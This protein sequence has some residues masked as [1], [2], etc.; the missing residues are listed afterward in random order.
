MANRK[1]GFSYYNVDTDRYQD[2]RIKRLKKDFG[3]SGISVYDYIL[4]EIY[5]VRGCFIAW[6][7]ST[8]FDVAEYFGLKETLVNEIVNYCC[9]VGLFDRELLISERV[10]TS[11]SIQTRFIEMNK[12][13]KRNDFKIPEEYAILPE[14]SIKLPEES[15]ETHAVCRKVKK[16]KGKERKKEKERI[17]DYSETSLADCFDCLSKDDIW[18]EPVIMNT[19]SSGYSN[20]SP[21]NFHSYLKSFFAKLQ[22]EGETVKSAKDAKAHFARWLNIELK[23]KKETPQQL[24]KQ[25]EIIR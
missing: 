17:T 21:T 1:Q 10:L 2:I 13:A 24:G 12:R 9:V 6:D 14:E 16:R 15:K 22:N 18:I 5:R 25:Y 7:E 11:L 8:A 19:R 20:F 3:C 4:C 23:N